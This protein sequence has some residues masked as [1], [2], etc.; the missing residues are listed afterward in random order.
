MDENHFY[1]SLGM[2]FHFDQGLLFLLLK[3]LH[4]TPKQ[5]CLVGLSTAA[6]EV[7]SFDG[8]LLFTVK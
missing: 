6:V 3:F 4:T 2:L 8:F 1:S 5:V 7:E